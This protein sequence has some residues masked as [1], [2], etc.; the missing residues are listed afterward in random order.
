MLSNPVYRGR[1]ERYRSTSRAHYFP[2]GDPKDG[3]QSF[4]VP[5]AILV[6]ASEWEAAQHVFP[7]RRPP[8]RA[9]RRYP[10]SGTLRCGL[11]G[12]RM[13]GAH[14]GKADRYYRCGTRAETGTCDGPSIRAAV[15]EES[16]AD[17]LDS[18]QLPTDWRQAIANL[19]ET[20]KPSGAKEAKLRT[21]LQRIKRLYLAGDMEWEEYAPERDKTREKL[22]ENVPAEPDTLERVAAVL[23]DV[24]P[25]WRNDPVPALPALLLDRAIL[26]GREVEFQPKASLRALLES[27]CVVREP[28]VRSVR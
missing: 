22:A 20:P 11:C 4:D 13:Q 19:R 23:A 26:H 16:F 12:G 7:G 9:A 28:R 5:W 18:F 14:N 24:G 1:L 6:S 21:H 15:A 10:L 2:E 3:K 17:W 27:V 25:L 8:M